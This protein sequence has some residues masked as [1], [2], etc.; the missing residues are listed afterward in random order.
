MVL[1]GL[2]GSGNVGVSLVGVATA[3]GTTDAKGHFQFTGLPAGAYLLELQAVS[4][5]EGALTSA[6]TVPDGGVAQAGRFTFHPVG[7][8]SGTVTA[9]DGAPASG[10]TVVAV[11][12]TGAVAQPDAA[13]HFALDGVPIGAQTVVATAPDGTRAQAD[14]VTVTRGDTAKVPSLV[15]QPASGADLT[16]Q[17]V[18][19]GV[20]DAS[21]IAV[22]L[23]GPA[24]GA[25]TTAADGGYAFSGLPA[26]TYAVTAASAASREGQATVTVTV[27]ADPAQAPDLTLTPVG[28]VAGKVTLG[29]ATGNA[30]ITVVVR[31]AEGGAVGYTDDAGNYAVSGAPLGAVTVEATR[32]GFQVGTADTGP[33]TWGDTVTAPD[34]ALAPAPGGSG[35][36]GTFS[37]TVQLLGQADSSGIKVSSAAPPPGHHRRR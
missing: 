4:T 8:V 26:G 28:T 31:G 2:T 12:G 22:T 13:G 17:V 23:T 34:L 24:S 27:G 7:G 33:V 11:V 37:G 10:G 21:G 20:T 5:R 35:S 6:V 14:G 25:T 15:L 30:G 3:S 32:P 18:L 1:A 19:P 36:L 9:A 16:G 29:A